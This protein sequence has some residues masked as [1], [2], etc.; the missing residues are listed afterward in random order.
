MYFVALLRKIRT[1]PCLMWLQ[2]NGESPLMLFLDT[3]GKTHLQ[4]PEVDQWKTWLGKV[5][6][7]DSYVLIDGTPSFPR[8]SV[9]RGQVRYVVAGEDPGIFALD[10]VRHRWLKPFTASELRDCGMHLEIGVS[11]RNNLQQNLYY[12]GEHV[13]R[14]AFVHG[15]GLQRAE[16]SLQCVSAKQVLD[17]LQK[18]VWGTDK[19]VMSNL[20]VCR[21]PPKENGRLKGFKYV[22]AS[23][24]I[25]RWVG[26][27]LQ[28]EEPS[29]TLD[30]IVP[31]YA[32][33]C[34]R[35]GFPGVG[36]TGYAI[37]KLSGGGAFRIRRIGKEGAQF[38]PLP[39]CDI[40]VT[41]EGFDHVAADGDQLIWFEQEYES[42]ANGTVDAIAFQD[43]TPRIFQ[44][45]HEAPI[46]EPRGWDLE[47]LKSAIKYLDRV[48]KQKRYACFWSVPS[49]LFDTFVPNDQPYLRKGQPI[50]SQEDQ[51]HAMKVHK[52]VEHYLLEIK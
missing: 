11:E 50:E 48:N 24:Y 27:K 36:Y 7:A 46:D 1:K 33:L 23:E 18:N 47:T 52:R 16:D 9:P 13:A 39:Y 43:G 29:S 2:A 4:S 19:G 45:I 34:G 20:V 32:R 30:D 17:V 28:L 21:A 5:A 25:A 40:D 44:M 15:S 14:F 35:S 31:Q 26:Y 12:G 41:D 42:P 49:N 22:F 38:V 51:Q 10:I 8:H 3:N 6:A 37:R